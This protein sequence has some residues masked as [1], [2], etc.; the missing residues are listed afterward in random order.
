MAGRIYSIVCDRIAVSTAQDLFEITTPAAT[1]INILS[2]FIAQSSDYGDAQAEGLPFVIVRGYTTTG[3]ATAVTPAPKMPGTGASVC[4]CKRNS[5]VAAT[6]GTAPAVVT[7]HADAFN[8]QAGVP[9][10][11][12]PETTLPVAPSSR[13]VVNLPV[14]P[15]D[16]ITLSATL[17]FE[18]TS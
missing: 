16:A 9:L 4:T 6:G 15:T 2:L 17:Y 18:E 7:L 11:W 3:T 13:V 5:T 8:I 10:V 14:A 1:G 12:T